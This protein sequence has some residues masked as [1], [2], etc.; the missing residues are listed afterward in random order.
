[1]NFNRRRLR[2]GV[3][4]DLIPV[5]VQIRSDANAGGPRGQFACQIDDYSPCQAGG[6]TDIVHDFLPSS[7]RILDLKKWNY[8]FDSS[9]ICR[10]SRRGAEVLDEAMHKEPQRT[11]RVGLV[12]VQ[13]QVMH[14]REAGELNRI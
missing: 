9:L 14:P 1:M 7:G 11:G 5:N 12:Q 6:K 3:D 4:Q 8:R 13:F 2:R 10:K